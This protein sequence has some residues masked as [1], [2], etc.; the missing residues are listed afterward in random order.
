MKID[1]RLLNFSLQVYRLK[2]EKNLSLERLGNINW[3]NLACL[4][5][6]YL[7]CYF[8]MWKGI[9]TSGK[10]NDHFANHVFHSYSGCLGCLVYRIIS[11]CCLD[12]TNVSWIVFNWFNEGN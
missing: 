2:P 12:N 3:E 4:A 5:I 7:I 11:L 10:V 6:I 8:S 9:K 1:I